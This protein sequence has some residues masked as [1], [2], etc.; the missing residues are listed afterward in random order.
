MG[1]VRDEPVGGCGEVV[2][3]GKTKKRERAHD[4]IASSFYYSSCWASHFTGPPF[5]CSP[6]PAEKG[7]PTFPQK[8]GGARSRCSESKRE[9][10]REEREA[11]AEVVVG[12][13]RARNRNRSG[14]T[15]GDMR[16]KSPPHFRRVIVVVLALGHNAWSLTPALFELRIVGSLTPA[17]RR[18]APLA[19]R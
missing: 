15:R 2:S 18:A 8:R 13:K 1:G 16:P 11:K 19:P 17:K 4:V 3:A 7:E 6:I 12:E 10:E 5:V 14:V 9:R